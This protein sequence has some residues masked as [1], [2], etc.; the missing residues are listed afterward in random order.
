MAIQHY[1][2]EIGRGARGAKALDRT[3]AADLL[4]QILDGQVS[5]YEVGAFCIAMRI[6]GET[7]DEMCGLWDAVHARI[8]RIRVRGSQGSNG[9]AIV[10]PSY[11]GARRLPTLTPLL[12]LL[13]AREG[14]P[15]LVHGMQTEASRTSVFAVLQ[16]LGISTLPQAGILEPAQVTAVHTATLLP[17]LARLLAVRQVIGLRNPGHSVAK[18]LQPVAGPALLLGSYTHPEYLPMLQ[19]TLTQLGLNALLSRG[20]EGEVCADPR[21]T[22]Q[23]DGFVHGHHQ[24]LQARAAG[25][26]G[27]V[28]GLPD[29][30]DADSTARYTEAVLAGRLPVPPALAQQVQHIRCLVD[31]VRNSAL[32]PSEQSQN[33][34]ESGTKSH[35]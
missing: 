35:D 15:V 13:L 6:K 4:G 18:L 24:L 12:A 21:R 27:E 9:A 3:Q 29:S 23:Y 1:I 30:I 33:A 32:S 20:L 34:I 31:L 10:I 14:L 5:D 19:A 7:A 16:R 25:T 8:T 28:P 2:K 11:N 17:A 22:P 26:D